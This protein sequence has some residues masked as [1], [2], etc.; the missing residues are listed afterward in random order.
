MFLFI[1]RYQGLYCPK[2][3]PQGRAGMSS[4]A[5]TRKGTAGIIPGT[6]SGLYTNFK[7]KRGEKKL[8]RL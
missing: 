2:A 8:Q 6:L 5:V 7:G 3:D 1:E 4:S